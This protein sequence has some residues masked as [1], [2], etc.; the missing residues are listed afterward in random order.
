M[1]RDVA[2]SVISIEYDPNR[3]ARIALVQYH[4]GPKIYIIAPDGIGVGDTI[5][6]GDGVAV[7]PGNADQCS[8]FPR[9]HRARDRRYQG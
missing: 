1:R 6:A 5:I 2:A 3:S 8:G 4:D 9:P 7:V